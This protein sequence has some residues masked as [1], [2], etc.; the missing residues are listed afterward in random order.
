MNS[1]DQAD[2]DFD[3]RLARTEPEKPS[4]HADD[5]LH[6]VRVP[7]LPRVEQGDVDDEKQRVR[8][9]AD[10]DNNDISDGPR[11]IDGVERGA[12]CAARL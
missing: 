5:S 11:D 10:V 6:S 12:V 4:N 7:M 3:D 2:V 1:V 9:S 8:D